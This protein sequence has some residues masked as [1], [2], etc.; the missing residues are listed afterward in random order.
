MSDHLH[1][2]GDELMENLPAAIL[3]RRIPDFEDKANLY[4]IINIRSL[5]TV[6]SPDSRNQFAS[7]SPEFM[8][9]S[10]HYWV[11]HSGEL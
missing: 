8:K 9:W 11:N 6:S 2:N 5:E 3:G 10:C 7:A 1:V 4:I